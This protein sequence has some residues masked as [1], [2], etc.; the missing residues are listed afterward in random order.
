[1]QAN[2]DILLNTMDVFVKE[3]LLD[4][5]KFAMRLAKE[6]GLRKKLK[7][8]NFIDLSD[9]QEKEKEMCDNGS[10]LKRSKL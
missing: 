8:D 1:M 4:W 6:Q 9:L 7:L 5:Q 3:P 2:K 10:L